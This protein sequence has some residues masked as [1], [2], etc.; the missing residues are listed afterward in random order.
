MSSKPV[1]LGT[2]GL[3]SAVNLIYSV[4]V[5]AVP[6]ISTPMISK[7]ANGE[8][9]DTQASGFVPNF[10]VNQPIPIATP[11][12]SDLVPTKTISMTIDSAENTSFTTIIGF[13]T[14]LLA[15]TS[16]SIVLANMPTTNKRHSISP[17]SDSSE[18]SKDEPENGKLLNKLNRRIL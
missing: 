13:V 16:V 10:L 5:A 18:Q 8:H 6:I 12:V 4:A 11:V 9:Q 1:S 14:A 17:R 15:L 2:A 7:L 3:G